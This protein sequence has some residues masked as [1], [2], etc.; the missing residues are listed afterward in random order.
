MSDITHM[1]DTCPSA[2]QSEL[3]A[4]P[5]AAPASFKDVVCLVVDSMMYYRIWD[6]ALCHAEYRTTQDNFILISTHVHTSQTSQ[7]SWYSV[8]ALCSSSATAVQQCISHL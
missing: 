1:K 6:D 4:N 3:L 8:Q 2:A 7:C 5:H